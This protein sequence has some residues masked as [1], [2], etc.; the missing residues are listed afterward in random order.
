LLRTPALLLPPP[1][2]PPDFLQ[3]QKLSA[4]HTLHAN[5]SETSAAV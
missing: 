5:I 3:K 4:S 2:P 1:P